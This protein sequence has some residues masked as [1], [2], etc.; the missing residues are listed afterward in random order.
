MSKQQPSPT[1]KL[2]NKKTLT[3]PSIHQPVEVLQQ[4][5]LN[6]PSCFPKPVIPA[7]NTCWTNEIL[8]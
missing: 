6:N 8:L 5:L 4:V 1:M 2:P 3:K 7:E